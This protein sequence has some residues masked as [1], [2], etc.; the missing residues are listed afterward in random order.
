[1]KLNFRSKIYQTKT[2]QTKVPVIFIEIMVGVAE[3]FSNILNYILFKTFELFIFC[4]Y[5][6]SKV[7]FLALIC[8]LGTL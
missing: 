1:M 8:N 4:T 7:P 5:S 3:K 2:N 6:S